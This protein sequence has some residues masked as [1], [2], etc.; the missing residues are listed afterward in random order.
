MFFEFYRYQLSILDFSQLP[1]GVFM[2]HMIKTAVDHCHSSPANAVLV[3]YPVAYS[4]FSTP[5]RMEAC[6]RIE[7]RLLH[8]GANVDVE[9]SIHYQVDNMHAAERR[10]LSARAMLVVSSKVGD[11][12]PW[13]DSDAARGKIQNVWRLFMFQFN[14]QWVH[15]AAPS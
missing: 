7:D 13:L 6:R 2:E 15:S 4:G 10:M 11:K 8:Y 9:I 14:I 12:S 1:S 5:A 3:L